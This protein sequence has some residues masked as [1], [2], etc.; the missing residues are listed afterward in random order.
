MDM[1]KISI[2]PKAVLLHYTF[3]NTNNKVLSAISVL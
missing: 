2:I 3:S 1:H